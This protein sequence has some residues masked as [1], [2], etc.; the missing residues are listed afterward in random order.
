MPQAEVDIEAGP[1]MY[2]DVKRSRVVLKD[3]KM[4]WKAKMTKEGFYRLKVTAHVGERTYD[5]LCTLVSLPIDCCLQRIA[6]KRLPSVLET[7]L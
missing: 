1:V 2:P 5:G 4:T 6:P 7:S 3:G